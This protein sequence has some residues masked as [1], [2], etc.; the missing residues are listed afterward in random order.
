MLHQKCFTIQE[1][2]D[3]TEKDEYEYLHKKDDDLKGDNNENESI[4]EYG[5]NFINCK[6]IISRQ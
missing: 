6:M 4:I 5:N 2:K 3:S 1:H